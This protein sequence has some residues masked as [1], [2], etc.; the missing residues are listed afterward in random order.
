[1]RKLKIS[2]ILLICMLP[3]CAAAEKKLLWDFD[4]I[5]T[6][7]CR[8]WRYMAVD[9]PDFS[10]KKISLKGLAVVTLPWTLEKTKPA[11][12]WIQTV[13]IPERFAGKDLYCEIEVRGSGKIY[14]NGKLVQEKKSTSQEKISL[15][16]RKANSS[17]Q[18]LNY[19]IAVY[20]RQGGEPTKFIQARLLAEPSGLRKC[21]QRWNTLFRSASG[22]GSQ[23]MMKKAVWRINEDGSSDNVI[24]VDFDD[25]GWK[26]EDSMYSI[27]KEDTWCWYRA[28]FSVPETIQGISTKGKRL[29]LHARFDDEG[30]IF[31]NG[32]T[33]E[34]VPT[35]PHFQA[36]RVPASIMPGQKILVVLHV[37]NLW[38]SGGLRALQWG[39]EDVNAAKLHLY[40]INDS[41]HDLERIL[42]MQMCTK[43]KWF[44][45]LNKMFDI[46]EKGEKHLE[47]FPEEVRRA[48]SL[49]KEIR[50]DIDASPVIL[51]EPYLQDVRKDGVCIAWETSAPVESWVEYG[52]GNIQQKAVD[53][54]KN[55]R[56]HKIVLTGLKP[57]TIYSYRIVSGEYA[58][59]V[60]QFRTAPDRKKPFTF[61][62]WGDNRSDPS[63]CEKIC[64][65]M[66]NE[67]AAL[68]INVGD[69]VG[70][71]F[72]WEQW[73]REYLIP[74]RFWCSKWPSYVA[75]GNHEY[76][77][78]IAGSVNAYEQYLYYPSM[79]NG[80]I[81][82]YWYSFDYSNAHF[83]VLDGNRGKIV[84]KDGKQYISPDD[85]QLQWLKQDLEK[86][87]QSSEWIFAF[88]HEP[89]YSECWSGGYYDGEEPLRN[90]LVP[91]L[92]EY[93]VDI[94]FSG[95]THDYERGLPHIPYDPETGNGN[96]VVYII[97]GGGGAPLD[98]HKYHEWEQIDLPDNK[99]VADSDTPDNG[100]YYRYHY[101]V[102]HVEGNHLSFQAKEVLPDG[103]AGVI[104][105]RFQLKK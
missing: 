26:Q 67:K 48:V 24:G 15:L 57:G 25:T 4:K 36:F 47:I 69:V 50:K 70:E 10:L 2:A 1:M 74:I 13:T 44:I 97:T 33:L 16:L 75:I 101:C 30:V 5:N 65:K 63:M 31:I 99:A 35:I 34:S 82:Q 59:H 92:E 83:I 87:R 12:Y 18:V 19:T 80:Q 68:V 78:N 27:D 94:L 95:H 28:Q 102:L 104:F 3:V 53:P 58:S 85:P 93:H 73:T 103:R 86:A 98:N 51:L 40:D 21:M 64:R 42:R 29:I 20:L 43:E 23:D 38:G 60:F 37:H 8:D 46:V 79:S 9:V 54:K 84:L 41:I 6:E 7:P 17:Q 72:I 76:K 52:I 90:S 71:G 39:F 66:A 105:D 49:L 14:I 61:L 77:G 55:N 32:K 62:V 91:I 22:L 11:A 88:V 45:S 81:H 56:I 96:N 100:E 89:P